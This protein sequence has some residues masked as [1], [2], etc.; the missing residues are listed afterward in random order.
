MVSLFVQSF[1]KNLNSRSRKLG[2]AFA[3]LVNGALETLVGDVH[4]AKPC[5]DLIC[6]G[7][8]VG[9]DVRLKLGN[10]RLCFGRIGTRTVIFAYL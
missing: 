2:S 9:G 1:A 10:K 8:V 6:A 4:L 7:V 3:I 5:M